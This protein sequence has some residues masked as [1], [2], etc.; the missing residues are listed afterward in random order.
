MF[1]RIGIIAVLGLAGVLASPAKT[2]AQECEDCVDV[3]LY[4]CVACMWPVDF[5]WHQCTPTCNGHCVVSSESEDCEA[6]NDEEN[7]LAFA[8]GTYQPESSVITSVARWN[9]GSRTEAASAPSWAD[10]FLFGQFSRN[11]SGFVTARRYPIDEAQR[12]RLQTTVIILE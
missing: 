5:G 8:T 7:L 6:G 12:Y 10:D 1:A 2:V 3:G 9:A 4:P 11:C